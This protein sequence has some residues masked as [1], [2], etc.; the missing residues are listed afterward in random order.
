M[1]IYGVQLSRKKVI[2]KH[3]A[4]KMITQNLKKMGQKTCLADGFLIITA[5]RILSQRPPVAPCLT[6]TNCLPWYY[7]KLLI[8][9]SLLVNN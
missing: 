2:C 4:N 3:G 9:E 5:L 7:E 8:L 6:F 1:N